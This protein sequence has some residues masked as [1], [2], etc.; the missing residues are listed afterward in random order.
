MGNY[1]RRNRKLQYPSS[2]T[3]KSAEKHPS[4]T[5]NM[6]RCDKKEKIKCKIK[7]G[8]LS[9]QTWVKKT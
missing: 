5:T 9:F 7:F 4:S 8:E 2:T 1:K 3:E 6:Y